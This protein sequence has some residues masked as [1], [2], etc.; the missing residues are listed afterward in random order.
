VHQDRGSHFV[1]EIE[2]LEKLVAA[3]RESGSRVMGP[4]I[5]G[6]SIVFEEIR[7]LGDL[8][9]GWTDEQEGGTYRLE[10]RADGSFFRCNVGQDSLR[11]H[12]FVSSLKMWTATRNGRGFELHHEEEPAA[13][14]AFLGVRPCDIHGM[15]VLDR[16][17]L[18]GAYIDPWYRA[19]R[20][21]MFIVAV[22]CTRAGGTCF[23]ASMGTGPGATAG[24]DLALTEVLEG[25]GHFFVVDVGTEAGRELLAKV[26]FREAA[27]SEVERARALVAKAAG[28][29][30]RS[31]DTRGIKELLYRNYENPRWHDVASRCLSCGN[32]TLVCPTCFCMNVID[33]SDLTRGRAER[34]RVWDSCFTRGHSYVHG[35]SIRTSTLARYRQWLIHKVATWIDQFGTS[36]CVGCGRCITW[37]PVA[38]DITEEVRAIR[39]SEVKRKEEG[40]GDSRTNTG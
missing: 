21:C 33:I 11:G 22:N 39:D 29:M 5:K 2:G 19:R 3:L 27:A 24:F 9:R 40:N 37:C 16:T 4:V 14:L 38:I 1:I 25:G 20:E 26:P 12:T 32:C 35:G 34:Q 23:C 10:K 6:G 8:P 15:L 31:M 28:E 17:L 18:H 7:S 30:G 36:G 13:R